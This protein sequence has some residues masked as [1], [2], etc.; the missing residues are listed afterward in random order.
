MMNGPENSF[1]SIPSAESLVDVLR[2]RSA[3]KPDQ[4]AYT[5]LAEGETE[6]ELLTY[7]ELDRR[8]RSLGGLLQQLGLQGENALLLYPAGLEFVAAF[9]GC[10][11]GGVTAVPAYPPRA[12][13]EQPR[14]SAIARDARPRVVLTTSAILAK[15]G[16]LD[17]KIP[18]LREA[19]WLATDDPS[20]GDAAAWIDPCANGGTLAFLQYTS[21]STS[22]PKGVMVTHGNLL[23]NQ[24]MIRRAFG[25][26]AGS[27]ILGWLPLYHDMGLIGNVLQPLYV[28]ARCILMSPHA[29]LQRPLRWLEAISRYKATTSGGPN[30]AY[31]LCVRRIGEA[32]RQTLDLSSWNVAFNGAEPIRPESLERFAATFAP[33]GFPAEAFFPCYGLAEAT[34]FVSGGDRSRRPRVL[35]VD[36][37]ALERHTA[38]DPGPE[39]HARCLVGCGRPWMDGQAL[40]VDPETLSPCPPGGVGEIWVAGRHVTRG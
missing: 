28:G 22:D 30:F 13:R 2:V 14:L 34:L 39:S 5:F 18:E 4:N 25:Q 15:N 33:C 8:A 26:D 29:F 32:E 17:G 37:A 10:L 12:N 19:R 7:A 16:G 6:S 35:A 3:D 21:G 40:V 36:A 38:V 11:Y 1:E 31:D 9:F 27:V 20:C 24:E 23:H